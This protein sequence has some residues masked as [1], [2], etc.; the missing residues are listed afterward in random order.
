[1]RPWPGSALRARALG[2]EKARFA[3]ERGAG[4][5]AETRAFRVAT[6]VRALRVPGHAPAGA[7]LLRVPLHVGNNVHNQR[8]LATK[9]EKLGHLFSTCS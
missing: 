5:K 3:G 4:G 8:Y 2:C 9:A 7:R 6:R 1:M